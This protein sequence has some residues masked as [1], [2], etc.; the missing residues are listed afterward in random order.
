MSVEQSKEN[1][2]VVVYVSKIKIT[3]TCAHLA[4]YH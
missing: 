1:I 4:W 2:G 3:H